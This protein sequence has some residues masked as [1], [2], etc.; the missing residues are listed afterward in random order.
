MDQLPLHL[1][2]FSSLSGWYCNV[3]VLRDWGDMKAI[4][5][6]HASFCGRG[7]QFNACELSE[8]G[9]DKYTHFNHD[10]VGSDASSRTR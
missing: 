7:C 9:G 8:V 2:T 6:P 10:K 3:A 5:D 1:L 4:G